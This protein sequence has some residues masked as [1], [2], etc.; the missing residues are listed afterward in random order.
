MTNYEAIK[1]LTPERLEKFL[2]QVFLT[3]FNTDHQSLVDPDIYDDNNAD[4]LNEEVE[5]YSNFVENEGGE[6]LIIAPLV[7]IITRIVE[8]DTESISNDIHWHSQVVLPKGME[9]EE[10]VDNP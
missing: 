10:A 4:W 3:G 2:D 9:N 8:F 5:E 7:K 6:S 1:N